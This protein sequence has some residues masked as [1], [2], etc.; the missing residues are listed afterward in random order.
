MPAHFRNAGHTGR[1]LRWDGGKV[2][3]EAAAAGWAIWINRRSR[4][5]PPAVVDHQDGSSNVH[6]LVGSLRTLDV[7]AD[8]V[9]V[10]MMRLTPG[11]SC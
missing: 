2:S 8:L 10:A 4:K 1:F 11:F 9:P 7:A 6:S 5:P 3:R